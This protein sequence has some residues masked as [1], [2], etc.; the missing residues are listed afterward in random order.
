MMVCG[1]HSSVIFFKIDIFNVIVLRRT[2]WA[3]VPSTYILI[4]A[5]AKPLL[6][7]QI[8]NKSQFNTCYNTTC[9]DPYG[10][11]VA[12][13]AHMDEVENDKSDGL[14]RVKPDSGSVILSCDYPNTVADNQ[15][16]NIQQ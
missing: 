9:F 14:M 15:S 6:L 10:V 11:I 2:F 7:L 3:C 16:K 4:T 8:H 13:F 5:L 12:I 1:C